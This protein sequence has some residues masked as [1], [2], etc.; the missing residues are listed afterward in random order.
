MSYKGLRRG[1][2]V[3][4]KALGGNK[5]LQKPGPAIYLRFYTEMEN[6]IKGERT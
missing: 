4:M 1:L 2:Q 5:L 3:I 6:L